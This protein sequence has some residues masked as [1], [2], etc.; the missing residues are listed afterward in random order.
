ML[1]ILTEKQNLNS[2]RDGEIIT[3]KTLTSA[4][5]KAARRKFF[6]GTVLTLETLTREMLAYKAHGKWIDC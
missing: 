3:A 4:K 1:F 5:R 6:Q 2:Y